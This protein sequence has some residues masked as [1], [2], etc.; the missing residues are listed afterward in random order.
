[1][2]IG[3]GLTNELRKEIDNNFKEMDKKYKLISDGMFAVV[4]ELKD[5]NKALGERLEKSEKEFEGRME[6][7][8]KNIE[9]L[10]LNLEKIV[11]KLQFI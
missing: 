1:M 2:N 5:N 3:N 6:K 4:S 8:D 9:K 11:E 10:L 7:T